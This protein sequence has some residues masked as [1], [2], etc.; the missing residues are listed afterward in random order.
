MSSKP[1]S[2]DGPA[3]D[4]SRVN[5]FISR[6]K[7]R[8]TE[9]ASPPAQE[10]AL[11]PKSFDV[12]HALTFDQRK[13]RCVIKLTIDRGKKVVG[14]RVAVRIPTSDLEVAALARDS[15]LQFC[16]AIGLKVTR[17]AQQRRPQ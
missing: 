3:P 2:H 17:R 6:A 5:A 13:K 9:S 1:E 8:E 15:I 11:P 4:M 16:E 12:H 14:K 7:L 10:P